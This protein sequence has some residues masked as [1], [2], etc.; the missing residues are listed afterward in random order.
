MK[1]VLI[2]AALLV[3]ACALYKGYTANEAKKAKAAADNPTV[4]VISMEEAKAKVT[5]DGYILFAYADGWDTYGKK[6]ALKLY[7]NKEVAKAAGQAVRIPYALPQALD[8]DARKAFNAQWEGIKIPNADNYPALLLFDRNGRHYSTISGT[9]MTKAKPAKVAK[10]IKERMAAKREQDEL[11]RQ[12][13]EA[14]GVDKA[15]LIAKACNLK[16]INRPDNYEKQLRAADPNDESGVVRQVTFNPWG[17]VEKK[18]KEDPAEVLKELDTM[19]ADPAY[20]DD[21]KQVFCAC[22]I[23]TLRR[24]GG[25]EAT[26]RMKEYARKLESYGKDTVLGRSAAIAEREWAATLTYEDGWQPSVLPAD[27]TPVELE[28]R[29]PIDGPGTYTVVFHYKKGAH[30]LFVKAVELYDGD[31]K[32]AE[33]RHDG[34]TGIKNNKNTYDLKVDAPL[35]NP[36]LLIT[37]N[38]NKSRD[39]Y[40]RISI[41]KQK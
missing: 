6:V 8:D 39:S 25:P 30:A 12:A 11:M 10:L 23:G 41:I 17:F 28:G 2:V 20:T 35:K 7:K 9:Y 16:D 27:Q 13:A 24:V 19:L 18:I 34:S 21:Q 22:A 14:K 3:A 38:M 40:G 29:L 4:K 1:K 31:T 32:V 5:D 36:R 26:K 37:F 15:R 33:D